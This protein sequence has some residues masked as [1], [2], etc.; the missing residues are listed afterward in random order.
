MSLHHS[1]SLGDLL[2][3]AVLADPD[4]LAVIDVNT[5]WSWVQLQDTVRII[6]AALASYGA[7]P[8]DRVAVQLPTSAE[9]VAVYLG[10]LR[11]GLVV[12]PVN[13]AYTAPELSHILGD[14]GA[15]L[16]LTSS[17][18]AVGA[19]SG[20]RLEHPGLDR[21]LVLARSGADAVGGVAQL[22]AD[23]TD[24][25]P[26][27]RE[28]RGEALAVLLYTSGTSGRPKAAMLPM[29]AL[30][31]NLA[32][33]DRVHPPLLTASDTV[34]VPLPLFHIF[35]LNAGLGMALSAGAGMVL[36]ARFDADS[37]LHTI[38]SEAV[39][40]VLGAPLEFAGWAGHPDFSASFGG[41]RLALSGS[42]P[43]PAELVARYWDVGVPLCEGY[44]LTEAAPVVTCNVMP[45]GDRLAEPKAGS[46][47]RPIPGVEVRLN[48]A[49]DEEVEVGDL[50][51]I[52][53]KG[54]NL[55]QGYWPDGQ[56][57]P[58]ADGWFSTG[59]LAV[60]DDDGDL[61]LVGRRHD[62]IL[63]NGFNVY[64]AEVESV[65]AR[66]RGVAEVAIMGEPNSDGV[67]EV[68]AYVV[69]EPGAE[70]DPE[71]ILALAARS[72]A[73]FK[74]PRRIVEVNALP[75]TATGKVM[76]WRLRQITE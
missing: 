33:L 28:P 22:L 72:L 48:D 58:D 65:L 27:E 35:G 18:E 45:A 19:G 41:V 29:R 67:D 69:P 57:G 54:D 37:S 26:V 14:S 21:I 20:L 25:D 53:V 73:R 17:A 4:G 66:A 6:A 15:R 23:G 59:D 16:L 9:F 70:L 7:E 62:L 36:G 74:L 11:A 60:A 2:H 5:R 68:V 75:H 12:V 49:A 34:F 55:F 40:V 13:P 44:G 76:K 3:R 32:Q 43:L 46:I 39:S 50:G 30:M 47:G 38:R 51:V 71:D 52:Q 63:V 1:E 56:D 61:Y 8:G 31:A 42:A 10:A 64:A 24:A